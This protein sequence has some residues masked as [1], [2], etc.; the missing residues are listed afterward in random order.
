MENIGAFINFNL[1]NRPHNFRDLLI[2]KYIFMLYHIG[3]NKG[4]DIRNMR[5]RL[6]LS[7]ESLAR[8]LHVSWITVNRW[9]RGKPEPNFVTLK[10]IEAILN[11]A[12]SGRT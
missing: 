12:F 7:Q 5:Q 11:E 6:R 10:G 1:L 8:I 9:E 3:M 4:S 2:D